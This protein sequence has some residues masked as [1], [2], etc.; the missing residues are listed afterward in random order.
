[1][2]TVSCKASYSIA[3]FCYIIIFYTAWIKTACFTNQ[4]WLWPPS[5][6]HDSLFNTKG[7]EIKG[8]RGTKQ[9]F[10]FLPGR[11]SF[12]FVTFT[13]F[14]RD[15]NKL[16]AEW[17]FE[18]VAWGPAVSTLDNSDNLK[19][20]L[21]VAL[22]LYYL[23]GSRVDT[24]L[25]HSYF[26]LWMSVVPSALATPLL[27]PQTKCLE[28]GQIKGFP[29]C[30]IFV[31][32]YC[33]PLVLLYLRKSSPYKKIKLWYCLSFHCC[34]R[35]KKNFLKSLEIGIQKQKPVI[36]SAN[37]PQQLRRGLNPLGNLNYLVPKQVQMWHLK[38]KC[39]CHIFETSFYF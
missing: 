23:D 39:H 4:C 11:K 17:H 5:K 20:S 18:V 24:R 3:L 28:S 7:R 31:L 19:E 38:D 27:F 8:S 35:A 9:M 26:F 22:Q 32:L 12:L 16:L 13:Q 34:F 10:F 14:S 21:S 29:A 25:S 36:F 37:P 2:Y 33:F 30:N 6:V 1:M 15:W